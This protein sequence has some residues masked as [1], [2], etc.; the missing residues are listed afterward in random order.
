MNYNNSISQNNQNIENLQSDVNTN[1]GYIDSNKN[2]TATNDN[3]INKLVL[4]NDMWF[5][6][7]G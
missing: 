2:N 3:A 5:N 7:I 4:T 1:T 6:A